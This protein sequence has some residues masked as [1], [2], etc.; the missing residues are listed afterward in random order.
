MFLMVNARSMP[1]HVSH[2]FLKRWGSYKAA[3]L[4]PAYQRTTQFMEGQIIFTPIVWPTGITAAQKKA[5][6]E[7]LKNYG[8]Y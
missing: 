5:A 4:P 7:S 1:T 8:M 3:G 2:I 6:T